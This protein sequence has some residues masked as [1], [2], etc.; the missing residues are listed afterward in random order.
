[1]CGWK[2]LT[3]KEIT[4]DHE[5]HASA[6]TDLSNIIRKKGGVEST[7]NSMLSMRKRRVRRAGLA[8]IDILAWW[9]WK[10]AGLPP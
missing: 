6:T 5:D 9:S 1:M 4:N 2:G 10:G 8:L 3:C 7:L